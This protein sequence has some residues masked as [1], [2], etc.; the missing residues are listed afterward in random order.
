MPQL[1]F[2][3]LLLTGCVSFTPGPCQTKPKIDPGCIKSYGSSLG[4]CEIGGK[5]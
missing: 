5:K 4:Y 2:A 3:F 1:Y